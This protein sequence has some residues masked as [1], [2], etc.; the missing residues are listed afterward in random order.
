MGW[1]T[2]KTGCD[3]SRNQQYQVENPAPLMVAGGHGLPGIAG[4]SELIFPEKQVYT[5]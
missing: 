4:K 2:G 5:C 1:A 3:S